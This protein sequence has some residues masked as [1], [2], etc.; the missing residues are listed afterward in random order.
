MGAGD[1]DGGEILRDRK[2]SI[3]YLSQEIHPLREGTVFEN[4]LAHLGPWTEADRRL[5]DVLQRMEEGDP[6]ALDAV[7][8]RDGGVRL[9]RRL[10]D[11][12]PRQVDPDGPGVLDRAARRA[13]RHPLRRLGD[14]PGP[15]R[16]ARLRARPAAARRADEPPRPAQRQV[17]RG[18]PPV[19]PRRDPDHLP[20]PRLPRPGHH[21]D[22]RAGTRQALRLPRQLLGLPPA[23]GAPAGGPPVVV[24]LAAEEDPPDAG[25]R[26]PQPGQRRDRVAGAEPAQGDREDGPDRRPADRQLDPPD[27][28]P[29]AAPERPG[30]RQARQAVVLLRHEGRLSR[31]RPGDR[32]RRQG[33]ARRPQRRGQD[34]PDEAAGRPPRAD[35]GARW[36]SAATSSRPTS[37]S[38]G[39]RRST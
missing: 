23:E 36:R 21:Q 2:C 27:Q 24:R 38:T 25:L 9:R 34:D 14:A 11:G 4:M 1:L 22:V 17:V 28:A 35:R 31:P 20:R 19:V 3:G 15:G 7:R 30:R 26:R 16:P 33:R 12:G 32:A 39:S 6:T 29:R 37:P 18:V 13:G 8:R 10:R 5:K